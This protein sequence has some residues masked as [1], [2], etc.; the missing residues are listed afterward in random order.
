YDDA[1]ARAQSEGAQ[2]D[3]AFV[4]AYSHNDIIAGAGTVALEMFEDVPELDTVIAPI[5]GGGLLSGIATVARSRGRDTLVLGAEAEASP[6]F[7]S[8]LAA[9]RITSVTIH[10]TIADGLAGNMESDSQTFEIVRRH[11]D[12]VVSV[13]EASIA[14]AMRELIEREQLIVE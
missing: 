3:T 11:V 9:G 14:R 5:G 1:E 8:S 12:R 6:V 4:S 2:D 13:R 10:D 7:T